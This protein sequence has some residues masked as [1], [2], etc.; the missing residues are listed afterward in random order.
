VFQHTGM[1][2]IYMLAGRIEYRHGSKTYELSPG[3]SLFFDAEALHGPE[4]IHE[5]PIRFLS[6]IVYLRNPEE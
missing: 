1:E 2:F 6:I 4:N 3:D 5:V